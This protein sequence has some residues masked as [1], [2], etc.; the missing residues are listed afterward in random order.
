MRNISR[1]LAATAATLA[2]AGGVIFAATAPASAA[3]SSETAQTI[4]VSY[5]S[6]DHGGHGYRNG[7]HRRYRHHND[8][9]RHGFRH[10]HYRWEGNRCFE[11]HGG[12]WRHVTEAY[13]NRHGY[14]RH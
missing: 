7:D 6:G 4:A 2:V 11:W 9:R 10:A 14:H 1:H 8:H 12:K 13:A 3:V 5:H